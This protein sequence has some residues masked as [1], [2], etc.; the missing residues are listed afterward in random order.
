[1]KKFKKSPFIPLL[2][3]GRL[4]ISPSLEKR[5]QGRFF[6]KAVIAFFALTANYG[7]AA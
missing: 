3:R 6:K 5:G 7:R 4:I 2:Q 1:M